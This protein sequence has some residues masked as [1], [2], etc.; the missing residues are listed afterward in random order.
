RVTERD[1]V[2][3][4]LVLEPS[5]GLDRRDDLPGHAQLGE[6]PERGLLVVAEVPDRL[7]QADQPFLEQIL[8]VPA[9]EEVRA[10]LHPYEPRVAADHLVSGSA[11]AVAGAKHEL[12]IL[13]LS[14]SL[15]RRPC[16][17]RGTGCHALL[18]LLRSVVAAS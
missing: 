6:A 9:G 12:Q 16:C 1:V 3:Q 4:G 13:K 18:P 17:G 5:R 10:R 14:L 15:L 7:A 8:G 11:I 2:V